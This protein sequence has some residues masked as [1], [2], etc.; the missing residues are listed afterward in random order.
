[1]LSLAVKLL[2]V[3]PRER[4]WLILNLGDTWNEALGLEA[5]LSTASVVLSIRNHNLVL[6]NRKDRVVLG[7]GFA[8]HDKDCV[9]LA[10]CLIASQALQVYSALNSHQGLRVDEALL[11]WRLRL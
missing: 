4:L 7:H 6:L 1:V 5:E 8:I 11:D 3:K 10:F 9:F 2:W